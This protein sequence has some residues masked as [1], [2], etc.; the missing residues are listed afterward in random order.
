MLFFLLTCGAVCGLDYV[1]SC[2]SV[3]EQLKTSS[4]VADSSST[5]SS[6]QQS[7]STSQQTQSQSQSQNT[8]VSRHPGL[9]E[10]A[11]KRVVGESPLSPD[12]LEKVEQCCRVSVISN[13]YILQLLLIDYLH[14]VNIAV[15]WVADDVSYHSSLLSSSYPSLQWFDA[16]GWMTGSASCCNS[17]QNFWGLT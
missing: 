17:S 16:V 2:A 4:S 14:R 15:G 5:S 7:Q 10:A 3:A 11:F 12:D 6:S 8:S 9:S 13:S 1:F